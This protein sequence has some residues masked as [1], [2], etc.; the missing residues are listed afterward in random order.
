MAFI[1]WLQK[2]KEIN[3]NNFEKRK[4]IT[5]FEERKKS[6]ISLKKKKIYCEKMATTEG[7]KQ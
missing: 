6:Q 5:Y 2:K 3:L 4:P 1:A 7:T